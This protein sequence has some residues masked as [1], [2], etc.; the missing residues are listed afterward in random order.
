MKWLL[1][2]DS[3]Y[4][5]DKNFIDLKNKL[6]LSGIKFS[7]E[8]S[9]ENC[10]LIFCKEDAIE[11]L[12]K[13]DFKKIILSPFSPKYLGLDSSFFGVY[14]VENTSGMLTTSEKEVGLNEEEKLNN[15]LGLVVEKSNLNIK[16]DYSG[17][18][19]ILEVIEK[20]NLKYMFGSIPKAVF[21]AGIMGTGKTFFA[22]C[23]AGETNRLLVSFNLPK[24]MNAD[25]PIEEFD[26]I[27]SYLVSQK[28]IKYLLWIDEIDKI[29]NGTPESE[30]IKNKFL[31]FLN[32]LGVTI[33]ID[34]FVVMTANQ[35]GDILDKFPEMIRAGRVESFAKLFLDF[36]SKDSAVSSAKA[37]IEKKNKQS[38]KHFAIANVMYFAF[39]NEDY[40]DSIK[41]RNKFN[42]IIHDKKDHF[43]PIIQT[44]VNQKGNKKEI[45]NILANG[46]KN[47]FSSDL[48]NT[49][50]KEIH[51]NVEPEFIVDYIERIYSD[52]H[53]RSTIEKFPYVH[54]EIKEIVNQLYFI[55]VNK[56]FELNNENKDTYLNE[57]LRQIVNENIA[58]GDA[59]EKA[60]NKMLGNKKRFSLV[61]S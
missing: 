30:H 25:N 35:V 19:Q 43:V 1:V 12:K 27:I 41:E 22:Q 5:Q 6:T 60:V 50:E 45:I 18:P 48:L 36:L 52:C 13:R 37:Y 4:Y 9:D 61:I 16:N 53:P 32:D 44:Y 46:L 28:G 21:L 3:F 33:D 40:F 11:L 59:G 39:E 20:L 29:F 54:A 24:I 14:V 57:T 51:L 58:I 15:I 2:E 47:L 17:D 31:S 23:L 26:K 34:A 7:E 49:L 42:S 56:P 10:K 8:I 55:N 38:H